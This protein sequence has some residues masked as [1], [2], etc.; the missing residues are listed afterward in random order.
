MAESVRRTRP[1][2]CEVDLSA[3]A[4]NTAVVREL[5]GPSVQFYAALKAN[6]Y[7]FGL[8]EVAR[9]VLQ[10]GADALAMAELADACR[11]RD[12][13]ITSPILLYPGSLATAE[14][15]G[16]MQRRNIFPTV[17]DLQ[18]AQTYSESVSGEM[19][20]FVKVDVGL[21]RLGVPAEKAVK[22]VQSVVELG[23]LT[24]RG[25]Y[26]HMNLIDGAR[27]EN[28]AAW[29]FRRFVDVIDE[30]DR[31]GLTIPVRMASSSGTVRMT[32]AMNLN[33]ADPGH[34]IYGLVPAGPGQRL[35]LR[36]A[37]HALRTK[38]IQVRELTRVEWLEEAPFDSEEVTRL[39]VI[40]MGRADGMAALNVGHVLVRGTRVPV[41][42]KPSLEH[43]RLDLSRVDDARPGDEV[44][45][46]GR[47]GREEITTRE[48]AAF[49]AMPEA[50]VALEVRPSVTRVYVGGR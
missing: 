50:G 13:A 42:A 7:G 20:V 37:L 10:A 49:Q 3:I 32:S 43:T 30:L 39:G 17:L 31:L 14:T 28:Y 16:L 40:P 1:N 44:V 48:V 38:L 23:N 25:I 6:A 27:A 22:F 8:M 4:S 33:A 45:I 24:V 18:S 29:Q 34:L 36:P 15:A 35:D 26:T 2:V 21:E 9:T 11:L 5:L 12:A 47:Q 41:L 46:I 19:P